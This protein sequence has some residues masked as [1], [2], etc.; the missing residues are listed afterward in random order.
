MVAPACGSDLLGPASTSS[1]PAAASAPTT[2]TPTPKGGAAVAFP[3]VACSTAFGTPLPGQAWKASILLAPIATTLVGRVEFYTD[4]PH[5]IL[6]P[7]GWSCVGSTGSDGGTQ[8]AVEPVGGSSP[9]TSGGPAPGTEGV[10]ATFDST[11]RPAGVAL[12]C[13]FFSI[14]QWQQREADCNGQKPPGEFSSMPTP[15][16]V[17]VFDPAGVAGTLASSGGGRGVTGT[18]V[19]PQVM[20]AVTDG[21]SLDVAVESCSLT[22]AGLCPTVLADFDVR[23]FPVPAPTGG[24][25]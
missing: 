11:G 21:V 10:F 25:A 12:V 24:S 6:G 23:E 19:F 5:S 3:V 14:P 1:A 4:G 16:V 9:P 7:S 15:D 18:V 20:P 13:P 2:T 17:S 22:N 8:L